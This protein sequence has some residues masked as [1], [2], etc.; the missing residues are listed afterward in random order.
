[1]NLDELYAKKNYSTRH[2]PIMNIPRNYFQISSA[3]P[4]AQF[5]YWSNMKLSAEGNITLAEYRFVVTSE[6][7][8]FNLYMT[9]EISEL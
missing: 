8:I 1:M 7:S 9:Q 5:P 4:Q 2:L 3:H 6:V